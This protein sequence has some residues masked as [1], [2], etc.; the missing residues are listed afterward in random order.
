MMKLKLVAIIVVF[1]AVT[2]IVDA[3]PTD[4][5]PYCGVCVSCVRLA[6]ESDQHTV[7]VMQTF[8]NTQC[9]HLSALAQDWHNQI[10]PVCLCF[11]DRM[12]ESVRHQCRSTLSHRNR[13]GYLK[14]KTET[15]ICIG[16]YVQ[17]TECSGAEN[18]RDS[19]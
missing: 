14:T 2:I 17:N 10:Y 12:M 15:A 18:A 11:R 6:E 3:M 1:L 4:K 7:T 16:F 8:T 5:G 19:H 9:S 13:F